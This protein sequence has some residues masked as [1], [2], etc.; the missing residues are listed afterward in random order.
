MVDWFS[1]LLL[2]LLLYFFGIARF[3]EGK[4]SDRP[5]YSHMG[6]GDGDRVKAYVS[7]EKKQAD[8]YYAYFWIIFVVFLVR[9]TNL[10][11]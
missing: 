11:S 7:K 4:I 9:E 10:G 8:V 5:K 1:W 2:L 3:L 6:G